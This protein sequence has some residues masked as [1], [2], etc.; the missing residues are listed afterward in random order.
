MEPSLYLPLSTYG[1]HEFELMDVEKMMFWTILSYSSVTKKMFP[2]LECDDV[3]I[4]IMG[5]FNI[6]VEKLDEFRKLM[7]RTFNKEFINDR[8]EPTTLNNTLTALSFA[9]NINAS[10]KPYISYLSYHSHVFNKV[11]M[12][13]HK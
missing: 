9:R 2:Q 7:L 11:F 13:C 1:T 6:N 4:I 10:C 8:K 12:L 5:D 3:P